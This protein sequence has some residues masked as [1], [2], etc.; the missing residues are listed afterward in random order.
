MRQRVVRVA[1]TA[2][3]VALI[4]LALPL[5]VAIRSSLY[6]DQRDTLERAALAGAVRVNPDYA[7]GDPV[8]L[9]APVAGMRLG[10]YDP[11]LRL[12]A[13]GGPRTGDEEVR[14]SFRAV[15][16]RGES[17]GEPLTESTPAFS[18]VR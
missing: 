17:G 13:G 14:G 10:L 9:P 16:I 2:V 11:G 12:K 18:Q 1:V 4:L 8:E 3:L 7:S 15:V 5:A 6:A